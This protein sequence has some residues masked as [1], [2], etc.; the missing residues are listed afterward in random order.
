MKT[1]KYFKRL[2]AYIL[3]LVMLISV[4]SVQNIVFAETAE[5]LDLSALSELSE[6]KTEDAEAYSYEWTVETID[7]ETVKTLKLTLK[8]A[9]IETLTLPCKDSGS[10]DR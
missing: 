5:S 10:S 1:K 6:N 9:S 8:G 2:T 3:T 7:E 4:F